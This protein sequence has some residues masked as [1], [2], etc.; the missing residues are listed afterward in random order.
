MTRLS[1]HPDHLADLRKSGLNDEMK[2][3]MGVYSA[4]PADIQKLVGW[5]PEKVES[6]LVFPYPGANGFCRVKVFPSYKDND[7]HTVKYLQKKGASSHLYVLPSV[8]EML[9]DPSKVVIITEGEKK[10]AK[11]VQ[12]GLPTISI[13]GLWNWVKRDTCEGIED[14]DRIVW[15][16]RS[17]IYVPDSDTWMRA[18]LQKAVF[19]LGKELERRGAEVTF[20]VLPQEGEEKVGLDD[21]LVRHSRTDLA[22]L[23]DLTLSDDPLSRHQVWWEGWKRRKEEGQ[24][25]NQDSHPPKKTQADELLRLAVESGAEFFH[26]PFLEPFVS[27]PAGNHTETWPVR[28]KASRLWLTRLYF[29]QTKKA[30]NREALQ[31]AL[32]VLEAKACFDGQR[33]EIHL[34][35]AWRDRV[36]YYDLADADW[37]VVRIDSTGWRVEKVS[38]VKFQRFSHMA[39]QVEPKAGGSLDDLWKFVNVADGRDRRLVAAWLDAA[40]IHDIPRPVLALVGDQGSAKTTTARM[41]TALVDPSNAA[42]VKA[43]DESELIQVLA[44]HYLAVF[45]NMSSL[46]EALSDI[47]SRAVTGEGFTKRQLYTDS[48]DVVFSYRRLVVVTG[49]G[50][51]ISKPDLLDR[52]IIVSIERIPEHERKEEKELAA[53]FERVRPQLVGVL[54]D[55][56]SGAIREYERTKPARLPRMADFAHWAMSAM[57]GQGSDPRQFLSD[58][59]AN[60]ERQNEEALAG[61][62]VA[63]VLLAFLDSREGW[64]GQPHDLYFVLKDKAK[65]MR[66]PDKSFPG[67][68]ATVGRRLREIRPNLVALG[69][70]VAFMD[71]ERPRRIVI[72]RIKPENA[73]PADMPTDSSDSADSSDSKNPFYSG[74]KSEPEGWEEV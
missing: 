32:N 16:G 62:E 37:R 61:S 73:V 21:F 12:E 7:G 70:K 14:L 29:W 8:Q 68:A 13:P 46:S 49:I 66:I 41:L 15:K 40:L 27:F 59:S 19:A 67:N 6:V 36:L 24:A 54:F 28:S 2:K 44:H 9:R 33:E 58:Y 38:P 1:F 25:S 52:S 11:A 47:L 42:L 31:S 50:L 10:A 55:R 74:R 64:E 17:I 30:P 45:D 22:S 3:L 53:S 34:R 26:T 20:L 72:G 18:D 60:V 69:W 63:T 48:D 57:A 35:A 39:A 56:L 23:Q 51:V 4:R 5:N 65:E 71:A 43:K